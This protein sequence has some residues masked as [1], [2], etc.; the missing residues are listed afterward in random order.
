[1]NDLKPSPPAP[2]PKRRGGVLTIEKEKTTP[3]P[4][5][6]GLG[7]RAFVFLILLIINSSLVFSHS[8]L[9]E[10][11]S[12]TQ[13]EHTIDRGY[14]Y[15]DVYTTGWSE[16]QGILLENKLY[17][18]FPSAKASPKIKVIKRKSNRIAAIKVTKKDANTTRLIITLKKKIDYDIVNVFGKGKSVI[19]IGDRLDDL[20]SR[21]LAW[22][23]VEVKKR[24]LPLKPVKF[25]PLKGQTL[26]GK[27]I[28]L[29]PGHGGDDPG[30]LSC[31]KVKEKTLTL[32]TAQ[33]AAKFFREEGATVYL[34]RNEDRRGRLQEIVKY[35]NRSGAD[36]FI[37]IHYNSNY[38]SKIGGTETYYYNLTS[39]RFAQT[40]HKAVVRGIRRRDRGLHRVPFYVVKNI[41][42]PS[43]L[44][45]PVYLTYSDEDSLACSEPFRQKVAAAIV[46]GVKNYFRNK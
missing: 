14:D 8:S 32:K 19:E 31:S 28:I 13:V 17:I 26:R 20:S 40:M 4:M 44:L 30:A 18:D 9:A 45:E 37:S 46:K 12:L 27:K 2:S 10:T 7:V 16:A 15:L 34:T 36:I 38:S 41:D 29:D 33:L 35:A 3:L 24:G 11:V 23:S 5:G 25:S 39:Q 22:E 1:M 43:V 21:Q 42:I 6:E